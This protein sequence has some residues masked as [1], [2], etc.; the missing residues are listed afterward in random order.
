MESLE[1]FRAGKLQDAIDAC[2]K[3]VKEH[4]MEPAHRDLL[5]QLL[6]FAGDLERADKHQQTMAMQF[7][8]RAQ[9]V[10]LI[11]HLIRAAET[12]QQFYREGRL[13]EFLQEP[14][15]A[16]KRYLE[17]SILIRD[18]E[19]EEAAQMLATAEEERPPTSG[20]CDGKAFQ[21]L[22]DPDDLTASVFEVLTS[23]GKYYW[24]PFDQILRLSFDPVQ[25]PLDV[26]WRPARIVFRD[27]PEGVVYLPQLY[28]ESDRA[29]SNDL[30]LGRAT[31]WSET[32]PVRGIGHRI[33]WIDE[34]ARPMVDITDIEFASSTSAGD[35]PATG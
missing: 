23:N 32:E 3:Q 9:A 24:V 15:D 31:E 35:E 25:S 11:R 28:I 33:L 13:P 21:D 2:V 5:S 19:Q 17:A 7:P 18:G 30:R 8:D 22:R 34:D 16:L 14:Q 29:E 4:P 20:V 12:R 26:L 10:S 1:L 6:C 27:A